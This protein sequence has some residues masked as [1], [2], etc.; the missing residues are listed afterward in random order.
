MNNCPRCMATTYAEDLFCGKCGLN[1]LSQ[2]TL[3]GTTEKELKLDD[4]QMSLG[5][6]YFKKEEY[7]KAVDTFEKILERDPEN[8]PAKRLLIQAQRSL[9]KNN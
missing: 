1:L 8:V 4:I 3:M 2:T 5:I 9:S 6:V 7:G